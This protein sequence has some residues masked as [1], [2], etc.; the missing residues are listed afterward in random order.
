MGRRATSWAHRADRVFS[1]RPF[2]L[3][4]VADGSDP[5][6]DVRAQ[7]ARAGPG[8]RVRAAATVT[9]TYRA[10]VNPSVVTYGMRIRARPHRAMHTV[11]AANSTAEPEVARASPAAV[12]GVHAGGQVLAVAA[13]DE[14]RVVDAHAQADHGAQHGGH[15]AD[16]EVGLE[17]LGRAGVEQVRA[18]RAR[19]MGT[20]IETTEPRAMSRMIT[21]MARPISSA[22]WEMALVGGLT[23]VDHGAAVLHLEAGGAGRGGRR[24]QVGEGVLGGRPW[25]RC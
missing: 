7:Q 8:S 12:V 3:V 23:H 14:Q 21:A 6:V 17:D 24:L 15:A 2:G 5:A 1:R 25:R 4:A 19:L 22:C 11:M 18:N 9:A 10:A 20:T 13:D 16:G